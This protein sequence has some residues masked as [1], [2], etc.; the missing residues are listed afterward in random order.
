[1]TDAENLEIKKR[2]RRRLVGAIALAL[3]AAIVLPMMMEQE[4]RPN[5]GDIQITIP[6]RDLESSTS[7]PSA[8]VGD[9]A[10]AAPIVPAP[11]EQ[12]PSSV[13]P[14]VE[15]PA[16]VVVPTAVV[17]TAP[18]VAEPATKSPKSETAKPDPVKAEPAKPSAEE[19]EAARARA[20]LE[21]REIPRGEAF[22]LQIGAFSDAAKAGRIT[23]DLKQQGFAAYT[24]KAG[25]VTRVR[26][27]PVAGRAAADKTAAQLKALGF[28]T[29]ITPR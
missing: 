4:P 28:S 20:I 9:P 25:N 14:A 15:A 6:D 3:L 2:A 16:P 29:V 24:E 7:R 21:G 17:P 26:V 19:A 1:M 18:V 10:L 12:A 27:G 8:S 23:T 11:E 22:V 13:L 5:A